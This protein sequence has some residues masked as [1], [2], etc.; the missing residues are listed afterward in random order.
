MQIAVTNLTAQVKQA[1]PQEWEWLDGYLTFEREVFRKDKSGRMAHGMEE[2]KL[3]EHNGR[4]PAGML[5]SVIPAAERADPP[6]TIEVV[7]RPVAPMEPDAAADVSWLRDYQREGFD[8]A[9]ALHRGILW[10]P[11]GSGKCLGAG[12]QVIMYDG[13]LRAVEDV[14]DGDLLLGPDSAPRRVSGTTRGTG[15]LRRIVPEAGAGEPWVCNDVHVLTLLDSATRNVVDVPLDVYERE[16]GAD[17]KY[18]HRL[19]R[20]FGITVAGQFRCPGGPRWFDFTV[21]DAGVGDYYG[22]QLD[23]DG[24]FL[25]GDYTVTHNTEIAA[26]L[27]RA[28]RCRWLFLAHRTQLAIQAGERFTLRTGEPFG[29]CADGRWEPQRVTVATFQTLA[30]AL[31]GRSGV[32]AQVQAREFLTAQQGVI[33]DEMHVCAADTAVAVLRALPNAYWRIGLSGTPLQRTDKR[34]GIA[35]GYLD[36]PIYRITTERL[37]AAGA[38]AA[39]TI[40][41]VRCLQAVNKPTYQGFYAEAIVNSKDRNR[42]VVGLAA[43]RPTPGLVFV[44]QTKHGSVLKRI[45]DRSGVDVRYVDGAA[46]L[47]ARLAAVKWLEDRTQKRVLITTTI[48]QEGVDIPTL[49]TVI[50]A[51]GGESPIAAL[52]SLGRGGRTDNGRKTSFEFWDIYDEAP[53]MSDDAVGKSWAADH[54]KNRAKT[55]AAEWGT[56]WVGPSIDG[57]WAELA[58]PKEKK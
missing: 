26:A 20:P 9:L 3:L 19:W 53:R 13:S 58:R 27:M 42:V 22:F 28:V 10:M 8:R 52:Q 51:S 37:V 14:R 48:M 34:S 11:T 44:R 45:L 38:L 33:A 29:V 5:S 36:R 7:S 54:A 41:M 49:E 30:V 50:Y 25:L 56:V 32:A 15:L 17:T 43:S 46:P 57:P 47:A 55:Y 2:E 1:A 23:G 21:E 12:T 31:S 35:V 39:P 40:R 4:F 16:W 6:V 18:Q 24:R